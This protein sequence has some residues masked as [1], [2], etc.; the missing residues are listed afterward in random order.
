MGDAARRSELATELG[1]MTARLAKVQSVPPDATLAAMSIEARRGI[2][3][4]TKGS[5]SKLSR[6]HL[7]MGHSIIFWHAY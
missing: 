2:S 7:F 4:E 1:E 3:Y 6:G 5:R